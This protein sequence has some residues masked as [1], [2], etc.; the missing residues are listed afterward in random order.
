MPAFFSELILQTDEARRSFETDPVI[1]AAVA[2][3][4]S[5][6]RYRRLL[7]ELYQIVWH[8]NPICAAAASRIAD[9]EREVRYFLY[10]HMQEESGHEQ[11]VANDLRA[12][13]VDL[14]AVSEYEA[15]AT[16]RALIGYN[17]WGA[18]RG[19]P[20]SALGMLYT[21]EVI[22][23]VYGGTF[24][25]AIREALLLEGS[26]GT[27]FINS[28]AELDAEHMKDLREILNTVED[29]V[30]RRAVVAS[31][32]VNFEMVTRIFSGI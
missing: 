8:F 10:S 16:T 17:Y 23:S 25:S 2:E 32:R 31:T 28:H 30:A 20:C 1:L 27:S 9:S 7:S 24:S 19:H 5:L 18:D 21:L 22:A 14:V 29:P 13:G 26:A 4:M 12:V 15:C 6:E 11:W 3:G